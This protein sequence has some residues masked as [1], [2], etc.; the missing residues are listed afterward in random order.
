MREV[1]PVITKA[2][3]EVGIKCELNLVSMRW[4]TIRGARHPESQALVTENLS[5]QVEGSMTV[6]TTRKTW[7]PFIIVKARDLLKLLARS[8]PAP[9]VRLVALCSAQQ[10][11]RSCCQKRCILTWESLQALKILDDEM[12]CDIV[13]IGGIIRNKVGTARLNVPCGSSNCSLCQNWH[14]GHANIPLG[15]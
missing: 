8:V 11:W 4:I 14:D 15:S 5:V 7:D 6:R 13:K 12:Q 10:L 2:L 3:K 9:Q 1:W